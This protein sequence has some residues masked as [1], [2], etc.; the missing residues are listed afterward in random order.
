[1]QCNTSKGCSIE[2]KIF[3]KTKKCAIELKDRETNVI[4]EK[5]FDKTKRYSLKLKDVQ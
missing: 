1:M 3:V 5:M 4:Q 2:Q